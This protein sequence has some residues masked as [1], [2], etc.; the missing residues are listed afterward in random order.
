MI[1][2]HQNNLASPNKVPKYSRTN[3]FIA[4]QT[5]SCLQQEW[6]ITFVS[7]V[8]CSVLT[9]EECAETS[10]SRMLLLQQGSLGQ[11]AQSGAHSRERPRESQ[12]SWQRK[13]KGGRW[14]MGWWDPEGLTI[15][16]NT[17]PHFMDS[18]KD[19]GS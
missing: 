18:H 10:R 7:H 6:R 9:R 19:F 17:Y 16:P 3:Q 4:G 2:K 1:H 14:W 5:S 11:R 8:S 13:E 15:T 12:P